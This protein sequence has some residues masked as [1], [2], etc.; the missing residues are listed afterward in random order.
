MKQCPKH[1]TIFEICWKLINF[2]NNNYN[3]NNSNN[4]NNNNIDRDKK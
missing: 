4:N 1:T 3:R 2:K